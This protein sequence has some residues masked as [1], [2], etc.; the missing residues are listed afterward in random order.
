MNKEMVE[1]N[2]KS[3]EELCTLVTKLDNQLLECRFRMATG[4]L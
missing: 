4:E 1:L 3:N 2:K